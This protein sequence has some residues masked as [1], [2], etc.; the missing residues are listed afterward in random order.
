MSKLGVEVEFLSE[1]SNEV[2]NGSAIGSYPDAGSDLDGIDSVTVTISDGVE[3]NWAPDGYTQI[4]DNIAFKW[5]EPWGDPCG[6]S[7]CIFWRAEVV[8]NTG[9]PG[10][11]YAEINLLSG[12]SVV[13]WTNE[14]LSALSPDQ[15]GELV[16]KIYG[17]GSTPGAIAELTD[18]S[19]Y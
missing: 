8:T 19:C 14:T 6:G 5:I 17:R 18:L 7:E 11:V 2:P 15:I 1:Y 12:N 9:C 10:G 4:G 16:F 13:D 3:P